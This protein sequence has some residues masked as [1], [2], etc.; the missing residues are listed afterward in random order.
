VKA[1]KISKW[2]QYDSMLQV[3]SLFSRLDQVNIKEITSKNKEYSYYGF[4][5]G[6]WD[7]LTTNPDGEVFA[8]KDN[9]IIS[10]KGNSPVKG[11]WIRSYCMEQYAPNAYSSTMNKYYLLNLQ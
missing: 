8:I 5:I 4:S 11:N 1:N 3:N 2:L 10:I 6:T 7:S 9:S